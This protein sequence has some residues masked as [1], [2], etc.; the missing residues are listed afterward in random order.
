MDYI[1]G[2]AV[3]MVLMLCIVLLI[4]WSNNL[5]ANMI[6]SMDTYA[7]CVKHEYGM[8]ITLFENRFGYLPECEI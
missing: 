3:G 7:E 1:K 6:A 5:T 4:I 8:S 2:I